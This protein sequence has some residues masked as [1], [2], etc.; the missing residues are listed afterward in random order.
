M[1]LLPIYWVDFEVAWGWHVI[2]QA[3]LAFGSTAK[4]QAFCFTHLLC[5]RHGG[6][7]GRLP[8][9]ATRWAPS[10]SI[11][12]TALYRIFTW[13]QYSHCTAS[14]R[15]A[16]ACDADV[17]K[18]TLYVCVHRCQGSWRPCLRQLKVS[19]LLVIAMLQH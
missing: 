15:D 12:S 16:S 9:R 8:L 19:L 5:C 7:C 14:S 3:G 6:V 18:K 10:G 4:G 2:C 17:H 11:P 1:S 13:V